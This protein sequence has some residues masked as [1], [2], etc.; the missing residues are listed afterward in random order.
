MYSAQRSLC[1]GHCTTIKALRLLILALKN[2]RASDIVTLKLFETCHGYIGRVIQSENAGPTCFK[3]RLPRRCSSL[4]YNGWSTPNAFCII[5]IARRN[6]N[7]ASSNLPWSI[8]GQSKPECQSWLSYHFDERRRSP[9]DNVSSDLLPKQARE[10]PEMSGVLW[11]G[12]TKDTLRNHHCTTI[13]R[14]RLLKLALGENR[15]IDNATPVTIQTR[16]QNGKDV[17]EEDPCS[18]TCSFSTTAR[19][20]R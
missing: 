1:D 2:D 19:L 8:P 14:L 7:S 6:S 12:R 13:K 17:P 18:P 9:S 3:S 20:L 4:K 11:M 10:I 15:A 5:V 16:Y